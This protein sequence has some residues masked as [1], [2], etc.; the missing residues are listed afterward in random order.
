M[1][2]L[3]AF[4]AALQFFAKFCSATNLSH[5]LDLAPETGQTSR[6][7]MARG[8]RE[9]KRKKLEVSSSFPPLSSVLNFPF[10]HLT[11]AVVMNY[12]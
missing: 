12:A 11:M 5:W 3:F 8:T 4:A 10:F 9:E 6:K 2:E 1:H 7:K